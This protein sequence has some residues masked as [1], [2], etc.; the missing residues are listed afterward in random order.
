MKM[1]CGNNILQLS[2]CLCMAQVQAFNTMAMEVERPEVVVEM[3]LL[4]VGVRAQGMKDFLHVHLG[5]R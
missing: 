3:V 2:I 4:M 5:C 1:K